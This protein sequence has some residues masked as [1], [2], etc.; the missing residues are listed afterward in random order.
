MTTPKDHERAARLVA[1]W[2]VK[3]VPLNTLSAW[4]ADALAAERERCF[5]A[6]RERA[7]VIAESFGAEP[8]DDA[9]GTVRAIA[10]AIR[11]RE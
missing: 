2:S 5:A 9:P 11:G 6:T 1:E 8:G 4:I 7:A 10:A 3:D